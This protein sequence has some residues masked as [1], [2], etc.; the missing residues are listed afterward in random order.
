MYFRYHK[1]KIFPAI[2]ISCVNACLVWKASRLSYCVDDGIQEG[3]CRC[4]H[5]ENQG[6]NAL[7]K[8]WS[9]ICILIILEDTSQVGE[10]IIVMKTEDSSYIIV[11]Q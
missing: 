1:C 5:I 11:F 6:G 3:L 10:E 8:C 7:D 4:W 9:T 2:S